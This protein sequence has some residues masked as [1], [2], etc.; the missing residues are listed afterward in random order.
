MFERFFKS[1]SQKREVE[2]LV[3]FSKS[4]IE[5]RKRELEEAR[6]AKHRELLAEREPVSCDQAETLPALQQAVE[7]A[8]A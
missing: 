3:T 2:E 5:S 4:E 6:L 8:D 7:D 1:D